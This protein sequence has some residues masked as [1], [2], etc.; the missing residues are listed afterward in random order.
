MWNID[1]VALI[2]YILLLVFCLYKL[3]DTRDRPVD[4]VANMLLVF[5]LGSL[6]YYHA[7]K[8]YIGTDENNDE[9]QRRARL[10]AHAS[11]SAFFVLTLLPMSMAIFRF[12]DIFGLVG[13][14][15]MFYA[16]SMAQSQ[17]VG[18]L[19]LALYFLFGTLQKATLG[20]MEIFQLIGRAMLL[21]FFSVAFGRAIM[22]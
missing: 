18:L 4:L 11:I 22:I 19:L 13:H 3:A 21:L 5:G 6:I 9:L 8:I 15:Y 10:F 17:T 14:S 2:G 20:G 7:R 12:Y 1:Y 16:V